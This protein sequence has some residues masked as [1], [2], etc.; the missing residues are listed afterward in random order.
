MVGQA[1]RS[2]NEVSNV[3]VRC[4]AKYRDL[5]QCEVASRRLLDFH[6]LLPPRNLSVCTPSMAEADKHE[7]VQV[8]LV[9]GQIAAPLVR[10]LSQA[11]FLE[12]HALQH[13]NG[14]IGPSAAVIVTMCLRTTRPASRCRGAFR[15]YAKLIEAQLYRSTFTRRGYSARWCQRQE[16]FGYSSLVSGCLE[17]VK[18]IWR[19]M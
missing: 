4:K 12:A 11:C 18:T 8:E 15:R 14:M 6:A 1:Q 2:Y 16:S 3:S 5:L 9:R 10:R 19:S 17:M 7:C 13:T